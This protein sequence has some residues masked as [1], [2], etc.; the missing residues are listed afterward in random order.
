MEFVKV[1]NGSIIV[2]RVL[3]RGRGSVKVCKRLVE[4]KGY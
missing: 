4:G 2:Y 3:R 1:D